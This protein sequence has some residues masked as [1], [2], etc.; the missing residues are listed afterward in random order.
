M[1]PRAHRRVTLAG[2]V[3]G[4][5]L[6]ALDGTVLTIALPALQRDL[7]T[8]SALAQW[9]STAYL[10]VVASL[11]VFAGRLGDRYG[12]RRLFAWGMLGFA[13]ASAGIGCAPGIGW[14]IALRVVQGV[15][16]ALLQPATLGM[17]RAAY[18]PDELGMP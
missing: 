10:I 3:V 4:A 5:V 14:V 11:L 8:S 15:C 16:G 12:H 18:P 9:T 17:L 1:S 2:S 6:V 13:A 7:H